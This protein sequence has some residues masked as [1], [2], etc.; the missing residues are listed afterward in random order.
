MRKGWAVGGV[1][2]A[3]TVATVLS[4]GWAATTPEGVSR[5]VSGVVTAVTPASGTIVLDVPI[6]GTVLTVGVVATGRT[7][8]VE[9]GK[10]ARFEDV[11]AGD[12]VRVLYHRRGGQ[13]IADSIEIRP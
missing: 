9:G 8:F 11:T 12:H 4:V 10:V 3:A 13:F 7:A 1:I 2:V 5:Q 6:D